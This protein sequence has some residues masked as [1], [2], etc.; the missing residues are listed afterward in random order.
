[1]MFPSNF[2]PRFLRAILMGAVVAITMAEVII[3]MMLNDYIQY[4]ALPWYIGDV[5]IVAISMV[6]V[7]LAPPVSW[8]G[9][10]RRR[11][12]L[13]SWLLV[14]AV[15][16][17]LLVPLPPLELPEGNFLCTGAP[18]ESLLSMNALSSV[19]LAFIL[20]VGACCAVARQGIW[21]H[22]IAYLDE[23][24]PD[25]ITMH[26]GLLVTTRVVGLVVLP[27]ILFKE[28]PYWLQALGV[29]G[30]LM[31][32]V[33]QLIKL[34]QQAPPSEPD[35]KVMSMTGRGYLQSVTRVM[36]SKLALS[37]MVIMSLLAA[38]VWGFGWYEK[39]LIRTMYHVVPPTF[40]A[41]L[42]SDIL[43]YH[44][45]VI[46][47][48][49]IGLKQIPPIRKVFNRATNSAITFKLNVLV[50]FLY[51]VIT[52]ALDC[53]L[54]PIEGFD[55]FSY[56]RP[57]CSEYCSCASPWNGF[58][59]VCVGSV[60]LTPVTF[61]NPC[62]AGCQK[63]EE[64]AGVEYLTDCTC[65][66]YNMT[67]IEVNGTWVG[68]HGHGNS[69]SAFSCF[70]VVGLHQF[71]FLVTVTLTILSFQLQGVLILREVDH[72][73]RSVALGLAGSLITVVT[74]VVG[75]LA[76]FFI[77]VLTCAWSENNICLL[78]NNTFPTMLGAV[79]A[80]LAF[81]SSLIGCVVWVILKRRDAAGEVDSDNDM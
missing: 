3:H 35:M 64:F 45:V 11:S 74:F 80:S 19:R 67:G 43:M 14:P 17:L 77:G 27:K 25:A 24:R 52:L 62:H 32:S 8:A 47:V 56:E 6:E 4:G 9:Y 76:Y 36:Q 50:G 40:G 1:M 30:P 21:C 78:Q 42:I 44:I 41:G 59:P 60:D 46:P 73:D 55:G 26:F 61:V 58:S 18:Q 7:I 2:T 71:L 39:A 57:N 49:L 70:G 72:R 66:Q 15:A 20:F 75:H 16:V 79:S 81:T 28:M 68:G 12:A 34:P 38:S 54:C 69:C 5:A 31:L 51:L 65:G 33:L 63:I 13:I 48:M 10:G 53:K 29:T 22:G 23:H 37:Y